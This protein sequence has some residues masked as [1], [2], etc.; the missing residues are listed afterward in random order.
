MTPKEKAKELVNSFRDYA[1]GYPENETYNAKKCALI[2]V[3]EMMKVCYWNDVRLELEVVK[4][5]IEKL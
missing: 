3:Y 5:E 4:K 2:C 1:Q